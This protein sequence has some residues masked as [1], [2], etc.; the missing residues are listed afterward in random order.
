MNNDAS[1]AEQQQALQDAI[2]SRKGEGGVAPLLGLEVYRN[3][4]SA[5]LLAALRDN[6]TV[7]HRALGDEA[8]DALGLRYLAAQ[9][10]RTP[11]IRWFG[12][13]LAA[14][15]A[16]DDA[17][18]HPAFVDLA[19]MDWALRDAFDAADAEPAD[20]S[21]ELTA[22]T[23]FILHP[24]VRL[25]ALDWAIEPAWRALRLAITEEEE[26]DDPELPEPEADA[27]QLL[28]W[29]QQDLEVRWRSLQALEA[30]L[31]DGVSE[32]ADFAA[33]AEIAAA[34]VG[35]EAAPQALVAAL[36]TWLADGLLQ[37]H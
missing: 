18:P 35:A 19:R 2:C 15:M 32:G 12:Q 22:A 25:L 20:G 24:S 13:H 4:Y 27:H 8:F 14:F 33:L 7:L 17:L 31:L 16:G 11:S 9:P 10:S 36:R 6:Y 26:S 28:V 30:A 21:I 23:R 34:H 29:R 1:L 3:A 5:R 37:R